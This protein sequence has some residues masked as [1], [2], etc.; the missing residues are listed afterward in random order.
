MNATAS[1]GESILEV[2]I[3]FKLE[4]LSALKAFTVAGAAGLCALG[5]L[6][7]TSMQTLAAWPFLSILLMVLALMAQIL[8]SA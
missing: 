7:V 8:M 4:F 6:V 3:Q 5:S 1:G 2:N